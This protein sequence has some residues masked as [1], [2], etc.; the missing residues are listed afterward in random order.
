[1]DDL[2]K[3]NDTSL[4]E[5]ENFYSHL[6]DM[7]DITDADYTHRKRICKDF[8]IKQLG[9]Y[10][11]LRVQSD[12]LLLAKIFENFRNMFLEI[13]ELN[14]APFLIVPRLA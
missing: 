4:P 14:S 12:K 7:E 8:Q 2:E 6:E 5:K 1:M 9:E 11:D 13:Y 10:H 3:C